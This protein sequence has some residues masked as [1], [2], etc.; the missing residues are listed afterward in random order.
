ME[1]MCFT[2]LCDMHISELSSEKDQDYFKRM[3]FK[4]KNKYE[5][6]KRKLTTPKNQAIKND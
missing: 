2:A 6:L 4:N 3:A 5:S 1:G